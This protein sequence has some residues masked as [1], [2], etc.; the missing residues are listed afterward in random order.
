MAI[1]KVS[2][3]TA[4][5]RSAIGLTVVDM[6]VVNRPD[7]AASVV[8]VT[9]IGEDIERSAV[10]VTTVGEVSDNAVWATVIEGFGVVAGPI[11]AGYQ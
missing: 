4:I 3:K 10:V 2:R 1:A 8:V 7:A 9:T 6:T 5:S 11:T